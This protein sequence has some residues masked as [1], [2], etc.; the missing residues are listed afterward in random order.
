MKLVNGSVCMLLLG[1]LSVAG[2]EEINICD[3]TALSISVEKVSGSSLRLDGFYYERPDA[4]EDNPAVEYFVLYEDG[5]ML[6]AFREFYEELEEEFATL[7][8]NGATYGQDCR[9]C[10]GAFQVSGDEITLE[11]WTEAVCS[12]PVWRRRGKIL[13]D[14]TFVMISYVISEDGVETAPV[15]ISD[16]FSFQSAAS[17]PDPVHQMVR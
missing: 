5:I 8:S 2:C 15:S 16:T 1:T 9:Q 3:P 12:Q 10:W 6:Y 11:Q 13:D 17:L 4:Q 7:A 14:T